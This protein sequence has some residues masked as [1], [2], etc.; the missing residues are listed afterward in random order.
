ML[1]LTDETIE[2]D[3][4]S[5]QYHFLNSWTVLRILAILVRIR[6][7]TFVQKPTDPDPGDPKTYGS[8]SGTV[9]HL[10]HSSK[11]KSHKEVTKE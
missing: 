6:I 9:V 1:F 2:E 8:G 10:H 7:L 4:S 5:C 3:W 11:I